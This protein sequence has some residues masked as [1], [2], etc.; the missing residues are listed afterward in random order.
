M[1]LLIFVCELSVKNA[2]P[3]INKSF[4]DIF[5]V[6]PTSLFIHMKCSFGKIDKK[7]TALA[8]LI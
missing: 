8:S 5:G 1:S 7:Y 6:T 4:L 3:A 2:I